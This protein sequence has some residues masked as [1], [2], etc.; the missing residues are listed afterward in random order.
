M[1]P[2]TSP[3][4]PPALRRQGARQADPGHRRQNSLRINPLPTRKP[5]NLRPDRRSSIEVKPERDAPGRPPTTARPPR[6]TAPRPVQRRP[7]TARA[8][9]EPALTHGS[10]PRP[11][12]P[13]PRPPQPRGRPQR[14]RAGRG[15]RC[16]VA[17]LVRL[18]IGF[19][20]DRDGAVGLRA[21]GWS[22]CRASTRRRTSRWP[23]AEGVVHGDPARPTRGDDP[24]PQR[25]AAGRVGRRP[26][27]RRRP[28][29][30][31]ERTPARSRRSSPDRLDVDYFDVLDAAAQAGHASSS[32]SPAGCPSTQGHGGRRRDRRRGF[33]GI[34]TRRDP[35]RDYPADDVAANLVGFMAPT[36]DAGERRS[37]CMFDT[38]AGRQGRLGDLRGR[39]RQPDPA[40]RQ[41]HRR[42]RATARTCSS[43]S[44][45]TCSGTPSGCCARPSQGSGGESGV[46]RRDGHPHRRAARAGRLPDVRRQRAGR[47]AEG[48]TSAP[49]RCSDV[50]EPGSVEKVLTACVADRRRQGHP[51][52]P[53]S[54][55]PASC[56]RRTGSIHDYFP[57][58][59]LHLTLTGVIAKSSNIGTVL[60]AE[61]VRAR[62]SSTTTCA[63]SASGSAPTSASAARPPGMLP[64]RQPAGPQ[65]RPGHASP[66]ARALSV[67]AVQM[68]AAVNTIANGGVYVT[69]SL[70]K[71]AATT[72]DGDVVGTDTT[73]THRVVS[74]ARRPADRADDGAVTDPDDGHRARR[75]RS[76][77]TGWPARPA[78]RSGSARSAAATT[79]PSRSPS[80]ASRR[81]TTRGSLVYVV[82]QNPEQRR[83]RR[84][85]RRPGVPQDHELR[86]AEATR[87]PPT[88]THAAHAPHRVVTR[89]TGSL[90]RRARRSDPR[91]RPDR[92]RSQ[93]PLARPRRLARATGCVERRRGDL[94]GAVRHR[95]HAELAA[96]PAR[97]PVRRPA[98]RPRAR[99]DVRRRGGRAPARSPCSPTRPARGLR[100]R[101]LGVPGARRRRSPRA[102]L[103]DLAARVYG[104][105]RQPAADDR[106]HRH[107][108]QDH[109]HPARRGRPRRGRR[110][111]RGDRHRRHPGRRRRTSKT[112]LTTPEAPDLH[113]LFAVMRERGVAACAMEVSSH[114]LV[115]G[116]V[117]GV[118]F[119][120]AVLHQP[121]PRPPRL[122][123]RRRGLLR[124]QGLAV[125]PRARPARPG[126]RRRRARPPAGRRGDD[127]GADLL[128]D[129]R[130]RRLA[131]RR[132]RAASRPA[133]AFTVH[134]PDGRARSTAGCRCPATST[135]PTRCAPIA[136]LRRGRLRRRARSPRRWRASGGVPGPAGAGRRR[137]GLPRRRRLRPQAR[138]RRA[139]RCG[140][141]RPLTDGPADRRAR[142]R[143]RPGPGQAADHG[144]DRGPAR[145][146]CSWSPTTTRAPRTRRRSA[147][148]CSP[149]RARAGTARRGARGR[150]PAGGDPRWRSRLA[151]AGDTVRGRRQGPRDRPG[152]RRHGAPVRRPR[153]CCARRWQ[154]GSPDDPA[155]PGRDRRRRRR[156]GR[157][158]ATRRRRGRPARR[159]STRARSPSPA[160]CSSRSPASGST[161]TTTPPARARRRGGRRAGLARRPACPR[162]VVDDP[163]RA[164]SAAL[165]RHVAR[166]AARR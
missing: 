143:R 90:S 165:A 134:A 46:G 114:A 149:A 110:A 113:A 163:V 106:R 34:D 15:S 123:R 99:R 121:R 158:T 104:D 39:R 142:R 159:S 81:P 117:D 45:A 137:P 35:V 54:P 136:A 50:Y 116:R 92:A 26:D 61:P 78:P 157:A 63:S 40:R 126:Q 129:R 27:D 161:A 103:G 59:T 148:R 21:P 85:G 69:P 68:A 43:P 124:G 14:R 52:T 96:G 2:P 131:R 108:G 107:P 101:T 66:S 36:G 58:G 56:P 10:R 57:H 88:G 16:A 87:V 8:A 5:A 155:D 150:R 30:D 67:N 138:R 98:R 135:W 65:I 71:G 60:A 127:P 122:P 130:R 75:R 156:H 47:V 89:R 41:Q 72:D 25:R 37:S 55:C 102:V 84:L 1:V 29:A 125:H 19:V 11:G 6:P 70:V 18:R 162:V 95:R 82:V 38:H 151:G 20:A 49:A 164:R 3:G 141:L 17:S 153:S 42:R 64:D 154:D 74:A 97:R 91:L 105:P 44:T 83:R 140:A 33:K 22:S 120:V 32:T 79:A 133:S 86:A 111:G 28:D 13:R 23:R 7:T 12:G 128:R 80:P 119:D 139:P 53:G 48:A 4:V 77:A 112:A 145:P 9:G 166:P 51:A 109:H 132:R 93:T 160:G 76:R 100:R 144:R 73:T 146:T 62:R 152:G 24:R 115:M 147:P 118:V 31:R 94:D